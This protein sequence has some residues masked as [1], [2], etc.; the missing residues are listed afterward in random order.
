MAVAETRN[1]D[2]PA[3]RKRS[4]LRLGE[5]HSPG[6]HLHDL[7]YQGRGPAQYTPSRQQHSQMGFGVCR[8]LRNGY[9]E[10]FDGLPSSIRK[11]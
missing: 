5:S 10:D 3:V 7:R 11:W 1:S 4:G 2:S 9:V 6:Y 8:W